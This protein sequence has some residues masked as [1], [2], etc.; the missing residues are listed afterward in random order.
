MLA[1]KNGLQIPIVYNTNGYDLTDT[2][3]LLNEI[4][5][6]YLPD[7]KFSDDSTARKYLGVKNYFKIAKEALKEMY[8]QVGNLK[9]NDAGVAYKGLIIRHLVM[10]QNLTGTD[11][12]MK[13]I[14]EELS[15]DVYVNI[16]KQYYPA[17]KAYQYK[18]LS[19]GI[20]KKEY[21]DAINLAKMAG[22]TRINTP[23]N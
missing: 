11:K 4:I 17:H 21:T 7:V 22:L 10:P 6:I 20:T 13:F 19:R 16:M 23:I 9:I 3:R 15:K 1:A 12:I 8:Y 5:D 14:A 2:L 18:E